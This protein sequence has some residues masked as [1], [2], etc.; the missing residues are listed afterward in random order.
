M[1]RLVLNKRN[2]TAL[3]NNRAVLFKHIGCNLYIYFAPAYAVGGIVAIIS[4]VFIGMITDRFVPSQKVLG[5]V[6]LG[7]AFFCGYFQH[8]LI[9]VTVNH[10]FG[11]C[12]FIC[13]CLIQLQII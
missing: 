13:F 9:Q 8:K 12:L 6:N 5:L 1:R 11:L 7:G 10:L 3:F 2:K 4:P